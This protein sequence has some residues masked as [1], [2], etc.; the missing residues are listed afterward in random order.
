M[1]KA[2]ITEWECPSCSNT[3]P[4]EQVFAMNAEKTKYSFEGPKK[5]GCGR[6]GGFSLIGFE[7][8]TAT[9]KADKAE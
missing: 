4:K 5:C 2:I 9:I 6:A 7:S 1:E 8:A 3:I